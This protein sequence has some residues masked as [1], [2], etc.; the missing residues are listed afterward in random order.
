VSLNLLYG[1]KREGVKNCPAPDTS[2]A[3]VAAALPALAVPAL[4]GFVLSEI[5]K[6]LEE[7]AE[8]YS[9]TYSATAVGDT[10]YGCIGEQAPINLKAVKLTRKIQGDQTAMDFCLLVEPTLDNT[11][12]QLFPIHLAVARAK[13]KLIA[14]DWLAPLNFDLFAPWTFL[15]TDDWLHTENKLF[16]YDNDVDL[17]VE[18]SLDAVW[19]DKE[20]KGHYET[21]A[22]QTSPFPNVELGR[23][24]P[25]FLSFTGGTVPKPICN[26][27]TEDFV[28][29]LY[30][31]TIVLSE[32]DRQNGTRIPFPMVPRS[33]D[34]TGK[35]RGSG[36]F[37][38]T[39][40]VTEHDNYGER[41]K[42]LS[43][44]LQDKRESI[45]E[46]ISKTFD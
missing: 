39:V 23:E 29:E 15:K 26:Q 33:V 38:L 24:M 30:N 44:K 27:I 11:A 9:A 43:K 20:Q 16:G 18:V 46:R 19:I 40:L 32:E 3:P 1:V 34:T 7:E 45:I 37:I 8:R 28:K 6:F 36:N 21:I 14:V 31:K 42:A 10:F 17:K 25:G 12:F 35:I 13:A 4:A 5:T 2:E 22:T 41:I